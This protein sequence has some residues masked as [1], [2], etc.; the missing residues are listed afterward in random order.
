[1][2][3]HF[4]A[5]GVHSALDSASHTTTNILA[6]HDDIPR[7]RVETLSLDDGPKV[8][9][10]LWGDRFVRVLEYQLN[11]SSLA[12]FK[13]LMRLERR[14]LILSRCSHLF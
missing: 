5:H 7:D 12:L 8:S 1:M 4:P 9:V 6:R 3:Q 2:A 11:D 13:R 14:Q 10:A